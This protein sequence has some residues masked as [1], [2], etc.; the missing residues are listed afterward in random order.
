LRFL[1]DRLRS[2][3]AFGV[4]LN[5]LYAEQFGAD[6]LVQTGKSNRGLSVFA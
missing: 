6:G 1:G 4:L 2:G 3:K 5:P